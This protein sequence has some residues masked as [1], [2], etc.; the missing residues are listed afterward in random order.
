MKY[1]GDDEVASTYQKYNNY[2]NPRHSYYHA[3]TI[4]SEFLSRPKYNHGFTYYD[5]DKYR[6][7]NYV[8]SERNYYDY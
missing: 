3:S 2:P 6:T 4:A 5:N 8:G 7:E 1:P